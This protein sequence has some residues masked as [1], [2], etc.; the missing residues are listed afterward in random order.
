[1]I[2]YIRTHKNTHIK[3]VRHQVPDDFIPE[4]KGSNRMS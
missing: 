4:D 2:D 1:M 3:V